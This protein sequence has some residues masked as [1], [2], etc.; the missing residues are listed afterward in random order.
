MNLQQFLSYCVQPTRNAA[1]FARHNRI[2]M[3]SLWAMVGSAVLLRSPQTGSY[4]ASFRALSRGPTRRTDVTTSQY[5][6]VSEN[7]MVIPTAD[8]AQPKKPSFNTSHANTTL[9]TPIALT[10]M[11]SNTTRKILYVH[12]GKA[13]GSTVRMAFPRLRC[14]RL[15]GTEEQEECFQKQSQNKTDLA[16][17]FDAEMHMTVGP[18]DTELAEYTTFMFSIRNP[19]T[20]AIS[21][22]HYLHHDNKV[23]AYAR[24]QHPLKEEFYKNCFPTL[25]G[26]LRAVDKVQAMAL[27]HSNNNNNNNNNTNHTRTTDKKKRKWNNNRKRKNR[28]TNNNNKS[29]LIVPGREQRLTKCQHMAITVLEGRDPRVKHMNVHL[30]DN[31]Q[32]YHERTLGLYA[33]KEVLVVRTEHLWEDMI[34]LDVSMGGSGQFAKQGNVANQYRKGSA[35]KKQR[36]SQQQDAAPTTQQYRNLCCI[37]Y[38]DIQVYQDVL[39]LAVNLKEHDKLE[40]MQDVWGTCNIDMIEDVPKYPYRN[41]TNRTSSQITTDT[42]PV[43]N[44]SLD[45]WHKNNCPDISRLMMVDDDDDVNV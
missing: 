12:V 17:A 3:I 36:G 8:V 41:D 20:R 27:L 44:F 25:P 31:Y 16:L 5:M 28:P 19:L 30:R 38:K 7:K 13:G 37:L 2:L 10:N 45:Q 21:A 34:H 22:Y 32:F 18:R 23:S 33:N 24:S 15:R 9:F 11:T 42:T 14:K 6:V 39:N 43:I 35:G 40:S 26:L 29:T 1:R 4:M